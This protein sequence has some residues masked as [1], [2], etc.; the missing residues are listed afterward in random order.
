MYMNNSYTREIYQCHN[1]GFDLRESDVQIAKQKHIDPQNKLLNI[2][3]HGYYKLNSRYYYSIGLFAL[4]KKL[5]HTIMHIH[6]IEVKYINQ[7]LPIQ[8]AKLISLA[9]FLLEKFPKRLNKFYKK[10]YLTDIS[11]ILVWNEKDLQ[12]FNLPSWYISNIEHDAIVNKGKN[13]KKREYL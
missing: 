4:V 2:L 10:N 5:L 13:H 11:E 7:L 6:K 3:N 9:M 12:Y 1:C 8:M